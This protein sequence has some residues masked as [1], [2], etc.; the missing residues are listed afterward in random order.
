MRPFSYISSLFWSSG[1]ENEDCSTECSYELV[2]V[3]GLTSILDN[4]LYRAFEYELVQTVASSHNLM[5]SWLD[6]KRQAIKVLNSLVREG[7]EQTSRLALMDSFARSCLDVSSAAIEKLS[8]DEFASSANLSDPFRHANDS[9][10]SPSGPSNFTWTD[11]ESLAMVINES[12]LDTGRR[13]PLRQRA[14]DC[15]ESPRLFCPDYVNFDDAASHCQ[16]MLRQLLLHGFVNSVTNPGQLTQQPEISTAG[17][18]GI[19]G[20]SF[21]NGAIP[22]ASGI[23]S[24]TEHL[25]FVLLQ[26]LCHDIP[27]RIIQFRASIEANSEVLKQL[28]LLKSDYR[29]PFRAFLE[30]HQS[31][32]RA[33][34]LELVEEYYKVA[35]SA[36]SKL[37][38]QRRTSAK[39]RLQKLLETPTLVEALALEQQLE[40]F[41][42]EI[43]RSLFPFAELSRYLENKRARIKAVPD[44]LQD[45]DLAP[46]Q[47]TLHRLKNILC[48]NISTKTGN[49]QIF[50]NNEASLG[51]RPLLLDLQGVPTDDDIL[52][53]S[54]QSMVKT[55]SL[56]E[57]DRLETL[58][59]HLDILGKLCQT[60][61][62]FRIAKK[63]HSGAD[64]LDNLPAAIVRGCSEDFDS[65]LFRCQ[66][67]DWF[68]MLHRQYVI[69]NVADP[70]FD[71]LAESIRR[72]EMQVSLAV[73]TAQSLEVVMKRLQQMAFDR[74]ARFQILQ[75]IVENHICLSELHLTIKLVAPESKCILELTKND[76]PGFFGELLLTANEK[77]PI[78]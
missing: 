13:I 39:N 25:C 33:P 35:T 8:T 29:A 78:G 26:T 72:A 58:I 31:L 23:S 55:D 10:N 54:R 1:T 5:K 16:R 45:E 52:Q 11:S 28:Y 40:E 38:E 4:E 77:L 63:G 76:R 27:M 14:K 34:S 53:T 57:D 46:L 47:A 66:V 36:N 70:S 3:P 61:N 7:H 15:W 74:E 6:V 20:F 59:E 75:D 64:G 67:E 17:L 68:A 32:Q 24:E 51:I 71:S 41:E 62:A 19:V 18:G 43:S 56:L 21:L 48:K 69:T 65:E 50:H 2:A 44:I 60:R 22:V 12:A 49:N 73:A 42:I 9:F 30:S 37:G